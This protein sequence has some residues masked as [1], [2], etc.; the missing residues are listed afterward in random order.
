MDPLSLRQLTQADTLL[1]AVGYDP[2]STASRRDVYV[3]GLQNVLDAVTGRIGRVIY[4]SSTSVYGQSDGSWIDEASD[5]EPATESGQICLEAEDG[6]R[7]RIESGR[8]PADTTILRLAGLYGP[9]RLVGR[10]DQL[11]AGASVAG[12]PD[13]WLNLIHVDDAARCVVA[14][15]DGCSARSLYLVSDDEPVQRRDFYAELAR[16]AGAPEPTFDPASTAGQRVSG[17]GKRCRN[18]LMHRDLVSQL[19]Y[20]DFRAGLSDAI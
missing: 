12:S 6:L 19:T 7:R 20:P 11:R 18:A 1:Y 10:L 5:C 13:A 2:S 9:G 8:L 14:C 16:R 15:A 4:I 17:F 3:S